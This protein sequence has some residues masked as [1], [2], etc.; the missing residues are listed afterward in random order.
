MFKNYLKTAYRN[1]LRT[2]GFTLIN[3][4]GLT[5]GH[6]KRV[7]SKFSPEYPLEYSFLDDSFD[8]MYKA[9]DKLRS[10]LWI[11][12]AIAIFVGCLGLFGLAAYAAQRR[13]KEIGIRK[14]L[15]ASEGNIVVLLSRNFVKLVF[16]AILIAS[17]IAWYFLNSWLQDFAYRINIS[18]WIFAV[19][20]LSAVAI[21]LITV[22]FHAI[23]AA[24]RNPVRNLRTE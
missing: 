8:Q 11:F 19:A 1:L 6:V 3:V 22:S 21:A 16:I 9:E 24:L 13:T 20:G 12:T 5:L 15:G 18:W 7:W 17:P 2:K 4:A 14:V 10:L 23:K